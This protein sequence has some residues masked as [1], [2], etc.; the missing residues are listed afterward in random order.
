MTDIL[1]DTATFDHATMADEQTPHENTG[2]N[3]DQTQQEPQQ[4]TNEDTKK[5]KKFQGAVKLTSRNVETL[6]QQVKID[7]IKHSLAENFFGFHAFWFFAFPQALLTAFASVCAFL[8][9]TD[10]VAEKSKSLVSLFA[11]IISATVVFIQT[12]GGF[13]QM[14]KKA[15]RHY[16]TSV[17]LRDLH[18]QL[19][20]L[21]IKMKSKERQ[22][23]DS[24]AK[25]TEEETEEQQDLDE[26]FDLIQ[27]R[28]A[29]CL[30]GCSSIV[31]MDISNCFQGLTTNIKLSLT[32]SNL[33]SL[34][35]EYGDEFN[36]IVIVSK[37][38][39]ILQGQILKYWAFPFMIPEPSYMVTETMDFLKQRLEDTKEMYQKPDELKK[40]TTAC[41]K[42]VE[43]FR[44][45][46]KKEEV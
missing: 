42:T 25:L 14:D 46:I 16:Q 17:Q 6:H 20:I 15:D 34:K 3:P 19:G 37:A 21:L 2:D 41:E 11:G 1:A 24:T 8:G 31:P 9:S 28:Y 33:K 35:A 7:M 43:F 36:E 23:K 38:V 5:K 39:D 22:A 45:D 12:I 4:E 40:R 30:S 29:Q 32:E 44:G 27:K 10:L 26:N 13:K 18:D